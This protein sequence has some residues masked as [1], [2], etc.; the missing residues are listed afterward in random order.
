MYLK[1][2]SLIFTM[3]LF[4]LGCNGAKTS[5]T[6]FYS[7]QSPFT[8]VDGVYIYG[9]WYI[10]L[11]VIEKEKVRIAIPVFDFSNELEGANVSIR[12]ITNGRVDNIRL[13]PVFGFPD[14]AEYELEFD[15]TSSE[16]GYHRMEDV[17]IYIQTSNNQYEANLGTMN[18]E[19]LSEASDNSVIPIANIMTRTAS[20]QSSYEYAHKLKVAENVQLKEVTL[21]VNS[22]LKLTNGVVKSV[23]Q[24]SDGMMRLK[25]ALDIGEKRNVI[26]RPKL[27]YTVN[28]TTFTIPVRQK[29]YS[30]TFRESDLEK[31]LREKGFYN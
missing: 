25:H 24:T 16:I 13:D 28:N 1:R 14:Y 10:D 4:L 3:V 18:I 22:E 2:K 12:N 7:Y 19:V 31:M 29:V 21:P 6:D 5:D 9:D 20:Q 11:A 27:T 17:Q 26:I 30:P 8:E 15:Y 23:E